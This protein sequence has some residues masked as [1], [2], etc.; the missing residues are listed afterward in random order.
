[1][2]FAVLYMPVLN[3]QKKIHFKN[4]YPRLSVMCLEKGLKLGNT[5]AKSLAMERSKNWNQTSY[6]KQGIRSKMIR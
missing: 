2:T 6:G 5:R 1:M 3:T 4:T